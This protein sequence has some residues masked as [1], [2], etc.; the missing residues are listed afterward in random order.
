LALTSYQEEGRCFFIMPP[1]SRA[2]AITPFPL[3]L[4]LALLPAC[5]ALIVPQAGEHESKPNASEN[6][7]ESVFRE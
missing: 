1:M 5:G 3:L 2:I 4:A 7:P 6:E